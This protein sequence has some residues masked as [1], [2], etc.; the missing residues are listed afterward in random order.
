MFLDTIGIVECNAK[1]FCC[2]SRIEGDQECQGRCIPKRWINDG[3][4]DCDNASDERVIGIFVPFFD[5]VRL[6]V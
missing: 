3:R 1:N 2:G 4:D 5:N 6:S